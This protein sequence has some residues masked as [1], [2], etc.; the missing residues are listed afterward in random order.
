MG[1]YYLLIALGALLLLSAALGVWRL[2]RRHTLMPY[3]LEGALFSPPEARLLGA[4]DR[5][6]GA[7]YRI[8]AKVPVEQV[9]AIAP[10]VGREL[11]ERAAER[12]AERS[13]DFIVCDA[14]S[15]RVLCAVEMAGTR[16]RFF[17][18][19][20]DGALARVCRAAGLPLVTIPAAEHYERADLAQTLST[21]MRP[22]IAEVPAVAVRAKGPKDQG[23]I[24]NEAESDAQDEAR[25]LEE[26][27]VA[28]RDDS[29]PPRATRSGA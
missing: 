2:W 14:T 25:L 20:A 7:R 6:L 11:R 23:P 12:L 4:L 29:Q 13:F 8:F 24:T 18:A 9:I 19:K 17:A 10:R 16:R 3:R 26:L 1:F 27:A 28:I 15:L 5:A 22:R 21:A